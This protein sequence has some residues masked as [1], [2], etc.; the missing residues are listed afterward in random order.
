[1]CVHACVCV[2]ARY[3]RF[4]W[5][6]VPYTGI[7]G[8]ILREVKPP[9]CRRV[10]LDGFQRAFQPSCLGLGLS[11]PPVNIAES[12]SVTGRIFVCKR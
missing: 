3:E 11:L 1:M 2:C 4:Q 7:A 8:V 12:F 10:Y 6:W 9:F 5:N